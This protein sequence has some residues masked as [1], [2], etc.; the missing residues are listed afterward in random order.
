VL[1]Q[2]ETFSILKM[3]AVSSS[4]TLGFLQTTRR[5]N[6]QAGSEDSES[7]FLILKAKCNP[8]TGCGGP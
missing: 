4:E 6:L 5:Y 8:V 3:E 2:R 1:A 7:A